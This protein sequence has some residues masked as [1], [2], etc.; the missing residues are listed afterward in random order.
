M[1][2]PSQLH[3]VLDRMLAGH[4]RSIET[5]NRVLFGEPSP[6]AKEIL[7]GLRPVLEVEAGAFVGM[8]MAAQSIARVEAH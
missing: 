7:E 4:A 8:G 3:E 6:L 1:P 2:K 5:A